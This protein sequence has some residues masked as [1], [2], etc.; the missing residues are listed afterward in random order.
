MSNSD[1]WLYFQIASED[2][3]QPEG[4]DMLHSFTPIAG[5]QQGLAPQAGEH[6]ST[7]ARGG[8]FS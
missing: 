7:C 1:A 8:A 3:W 5:G 4:E 6:G 2:A